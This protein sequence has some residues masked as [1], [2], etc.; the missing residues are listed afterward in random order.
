MIKV[1]ATDL[2]GTLLKPKKKFSLVEKNNRKFIQNFYGDVVI[3]SG[4]RAKFCAKVCNKLKIQHNFIALNGSVIVKNGKIIYTQSLKKTI[5]NNILIFLENN[6]DDFEFLTYDRYD[7]IT[8]YTN[9]KASKV[10]F[11]YLKSFIKLGRLCEKIKV[12]NNIVKSQLNDNTEI[13]KVII[14]NNNIEDIANIL[15]EKF[16]DHFE[17]FVSSHSIEISPKGVNKGE[18]LKYLLKTTKVKKDEVFVV[19]D[20]ESDI[21]MF[22]NF[23]NSFLVLNN[24]N[25]LKIKTKYN[26]EKFSDLDKYTRLN[27]N[28][29]EE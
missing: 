13:Y 28:F 12:N 26:I 3:S 25:Y 27:N 11:K 23:E 29:L 5:L 8:C 18:A 22:E 19:G 4:R 1:I 7:K 6:Y 15:K 17:F 24:D 20:A 2:D 14:Y 21:S 16:S 10:R 9:K